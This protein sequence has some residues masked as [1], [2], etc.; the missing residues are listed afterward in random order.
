[1]EQV[2]ADSSQNNKLWLKKGVYV[3]YTN[4]L[5]PINI[6]LPNGTR[7]VFE[8]LNAPVVLRWE[9]VE[10]TEGKAHLNVTFLIDGNVRISDDEMSSNRILYLKTF[11]T[12]VDIQTGDAFVN[13]EPIGKLCFWIID[14]VTLGQKIVVA[15]PPSDLI[16]GNVTEFHA[17]NLAGRRIETYVVEIFQLNPFACS[18]LTFDKET[19][20]AL[21]YTLMGPIE[22]IP[23]SIHIYEFNNGTIYNITQYAKTRFSEI[24][25]I[26]GNYSLMLNDTNIEIGLELQATSYEIYIIMFFGLFISLFVILVWVNRKTRTRKK[27]SNR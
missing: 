14:N 11:L 19:G 2:L 5:V 23:G 4:N 18:L 22:I 1:M 7:I 25:G 17:V 13:G 8:S 6:L 21:T 9:I 24:I 20:I 12:D 3:K 10:I 15:S 16:L 26:E 27:I